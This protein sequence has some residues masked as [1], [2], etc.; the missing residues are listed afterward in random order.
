AAAR[1]ARGAVERAQ[2]A[3]H[4]SGDPAASR[5]ATASSPGPHAIA[6]DQDRDAMGA[7]SDSRA[8]NQAPFRRLVLG[9]GEGQKSKRPSARKP[10]PLAAADFF[11]LN[12]IR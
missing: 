3:R 11:P 10:R 6:G 12:G 7:V 8:G 2:V 1:Y 4:E 5:R 9:G